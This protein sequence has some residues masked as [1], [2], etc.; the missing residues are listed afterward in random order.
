MDETMSNSPTVTWRDDGGTVTF[1]LDGVGPRAAEQLAA[2]AWNPAGEGWEKPFPRDA[3]GIEDVKRN[4]P[5]LAG[6]MLQQMLVPTFGWEA[7][8]EAFAARASA[9]GLDWWLTGSGATALRVPDVVP[10]DLDIILDESQL[11]L[12]AEVFADVLIEPL[13]ETRG[14]VTRAYGV[15]FLG[16]RIDLAAGPEAFVDEPEPVDFGPWAANLLEA[17]DWRG[18]VI[19]VPPLSVQAAVNRRRGRDERAAQIEAVLAAESGEG[20][21]C[22]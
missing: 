9:A 15:I 19:R 2:A 3:H 13:G 5:R 4:L 7:A 18:F 21:A 6:P 11:A 10:H 1:R 14:W 17:V 12:A 16:M 20:A 8:L 22:T